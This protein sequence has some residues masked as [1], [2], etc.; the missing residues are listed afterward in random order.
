[1]GRPFDP[2]SSG[3]PAQSMDV[4]GERMI[5]Q[6]TVFDVHRNARVL[7]MPASNSEKAI[8]NVAAQAT[9]ELGKPFQF[10]FLLF[11]LEHWP[12]PQL[13]IHEKL[14][15]DQVVAPFAVDNPV[16]VC[17]LSI[18]KDAAPFAAMVRVA[19]A[20]DLRRAAYQALA[21]VH[22]LW[23]N[24]RHRAPFAKS[25]FRAADSAKYKAASDGPR[26]IHGTVVRRW[27]NTRAL[28]SLPVIF[29]ASGC[30]SSALLVSQC[31]RKAGRKPAGW[32]S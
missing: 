14:P 27:P 20:C 30:C 2:S 6:F 3:L 5:R 22:H 1:M 25:A 32:H 16:Q 31:V 26:C 9:P 7:P 10:R 17:T 4:S 15:P 21:A 18:D 23:V 11:T 29:H 12:E 28:L 8:V 13:V 24:N 19:D